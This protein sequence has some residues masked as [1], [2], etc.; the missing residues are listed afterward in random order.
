M[1]WVTVFPRIRRFV[2]TGA[3]LEIAPGFGRWTGYLRH[4]CRELVGVDLSE[5]CVQA[6]RTRFE[7]DRHVRF[8]Q[9]DG[10]SLEAIRDGSVDF[11]FSLDS[12]VHVEA[13]VLQGYLG[14]LGRKLR[15]DGVGFFHHSNLGSYRNPETGVLEVPNSHWRAESVG[16]DDFVR[17]CEQAGLVCLSQETIAWGD[18]VH[19]DCFSTFTR[20][21][22]IHERPYVRW[23]NPAFMDEVARARQL[24]QLYGL[25]EAGAHPFPSAPRRRVVVGSRRLWRRLRMWT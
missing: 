7:D 20:G 18:A 12:L 25:A 16:A 21:G 11:V 1:W 24:G 4:L 10:A 5:R 23:E 3:L 14:Q 22:S 9:N 8:V 17:F 15:P 6:C 2:P 13:D 19:N